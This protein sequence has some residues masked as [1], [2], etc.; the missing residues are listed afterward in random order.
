MWES[1]CV[2]RWATGG[3]SEKSVNSGC[4]IPDPAHAQVATCFGEFEGVAKICDQEAGIACMGGG[5]SVSL[6]QSG[7]LEKSF[8]KL[9][10]TPLPKQLEKLP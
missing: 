4:W 5:T 7:K 1:G 10:Q 9:N 8:Q 3:A 2:E 6:L